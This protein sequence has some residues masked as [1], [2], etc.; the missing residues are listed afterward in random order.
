MKG[1]LRP[2]AD[3]CIGRGL[4]AQKTYPDDTD[5]TGE[6]SRKRALTGLSTVLSNCTLPFVFNKTLMGGGS[7]AEGT[8]AEGCKVGFADLDPSFAAKAAALSG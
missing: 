1:I 8:Q 2:T 7:L 4:Q 5:S 3:R 6:N